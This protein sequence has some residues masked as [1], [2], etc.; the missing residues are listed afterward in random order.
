M[1]ITYIILVSWFIGRNKQKSKPINIVH[2]GRA[3]L[4]TWVATE[5]HL[6]LVLSKLHDA[7]INGLKC[8]VLLVQCHEIYIKITSFNQVKLFSSVMFK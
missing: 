2:F 8:I 7:E 5:S 4:T 3:Y 6:S 1:N